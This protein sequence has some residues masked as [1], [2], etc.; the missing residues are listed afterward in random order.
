M[1]LGGSYQGEIILETSG[2]EEEEF[3][4]R[5][6]C[7]PTPAAPN[8]GPGNQ[9]STVGGT[10]YVILR[11]CRQPEL[12][13]EV[14]QTA[15]S[16]EV[17]GELYRSMLQSSPSSSFNAFFDPETDPLLTQISAMIASGRARPSIPEYFRVSVQLQA[18]FEAAISGSTPV[19]EITRR[20]A[21]FVS[22][23]SGRDLGTP[24]RA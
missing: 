11:Q 21:E 6:G 20:T 9:V 23:I 16:H 24:E 3:T 5:V 1:A 14:L 12:V 19:D 13:M 10:S 22:V 8:G 17:V 18:M 4:E 2:W 7:A 15:V